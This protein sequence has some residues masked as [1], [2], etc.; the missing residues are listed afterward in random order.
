MCK[1]EE[2]RALDTRGFV[3]HHLGSIKEEDVYMFRDVGRKVKWC[4]DVNGD[5]YFLKNDGD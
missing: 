5:T 2:G 1:R 4:E 3:C